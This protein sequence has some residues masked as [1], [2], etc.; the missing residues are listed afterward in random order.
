MF[1]TGKNEVLKTFKEA[2]SK[3]ECQNLLCMAFPPSLSSSLFCHLPGSLPPSLPWLGH[4]SR[5]PPQKDPLDTLPMSP[6]L[7]MDG[8]F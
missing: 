2:K 5:L 4:S 6:T 1:K 8:S 3:L 7:V